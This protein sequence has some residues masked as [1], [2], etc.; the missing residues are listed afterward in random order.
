M[1]SSG[2]KT[3]TTC[4]SVSRTARPP[5]MTNGSRCPRWPSS[6]SVTWSTCSGTVRSLCRTLA[7]GRRPPAGA[8]CSEPLAVPSDSSPRSRPITTSFYAS[9]RKTSPTRSN[10]SVGSITRT[11]AASTPR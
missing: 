7:S 10:R 1:R 9:C 11:G 2:P 5:R 8:S 3:A 6:T 4:L